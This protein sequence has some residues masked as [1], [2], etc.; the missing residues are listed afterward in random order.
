MSG[1]A[2]AHVP[3]STSLPPP[4]VRF[5]V[6][7]FNI[8][9]GRVGA[10]W[11]YVPWRLRAGVSMLDADVLGVQE[12]DRRIVRTYFMDQSELC[13]RAARATASVFGY[14][15]WFGPL[16]RYGNSLVVRGGVT[17]REVF[18]L[19]VEEGRERRVAI[20]AEAWVQGHRLM[21]AVTHLQNHEPEALAQL[22]FLMDRLARLSGPV[23]LL[24][25]LNLHPPEVTSIAE[26]A[27]FTV[28]GGGNSS[29][30]DNPWHRIDHIVAKGMVFEHVDVPR[31]PVSDHRPVIATVRL[32]TADPPGPAWARAKPRPVQ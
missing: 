22:G 11:P 2:A 18:D 5:R 21:V 6:A 29:G 16:G 28:A 31:P 1:P 17:H 27:G 8:H 23:L 26:P 7:T 25:D 15:R 14:A 30:V 12:V 4:G 9:H 32:D 20:L 24:G 19:P 13:R 10:H 3:A